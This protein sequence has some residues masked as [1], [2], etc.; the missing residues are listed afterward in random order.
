MSPR[1]LG[2]SQ[3]SYY[4]NQLKKP[5]AAKDAWLVCLRLLSLTW[6]FWVFLGP[7]GSFWVNYYWL[8]WAFLSLVGPYW[9]SLG[10][11]EPYW[12]GLTGPHWA[13][14][15]LFGPY[16][17][18][19]AVSTTT[20]TDFY[21]DITLL[22]IFLTYGNLGYFTLSMLPTQFQYRIL[23]ICLVCDLIQS[24]LN[25]I[26]PYSHSWGHTYTNLKIQ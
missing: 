26:K 24:P 11:Y 6:S 21:A 1:Y 14:L 8:Y 20:L 22:V 16:C 19:L 9:A 17:A 18:L 7:S 15:G 13:L 23:T 3:V 4:I 5:E 25:P 10:L 12:A 2:P